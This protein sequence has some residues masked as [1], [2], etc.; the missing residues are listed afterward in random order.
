MLLKKASIYGCV[1]Q[2]FKECISTMEVNMAFDD[3]ASRLSVA[4]AADHNDCCP[5]YRQGWILLK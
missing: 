2:G 1:L 4:G 5:G 3:E